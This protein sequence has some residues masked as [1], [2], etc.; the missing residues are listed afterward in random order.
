HAT[1]GCW[2]AETMSK[3]KLAI[4]SSILLNTA[5]AAPALC[6]SHPLAHIGPFA[7]RFADRERYPASVQRSA[8]PRRTITTHSA[9]RLLGQQYTIIDAPDAGNSQGQGTRVYCINASGTVSGQYRD[10]TSLMHAYVRTTDNTFTV[11]S[12]GKYFTE[13][14]CL[15]DSGDTS[16][17]Y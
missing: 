1:F 6:A 2:R 11:T 3:S 7:A 12:I 14:G 9:V 4:L 5:L 10:S 17:D 15:N 13:G 8:R 16:G